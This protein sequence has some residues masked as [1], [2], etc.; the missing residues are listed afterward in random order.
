[1]EQTTLHNVETEEIKECQTKRHGRA[2]M[3]KSL[4]TF[5]L[6]HLQNIRKKKKNQFWLNV[7]SSQLRWAGDRG[8]WERDGRI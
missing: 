3:G 6:Q 5:L 2:K 7:E 4:R 8:G 1:M